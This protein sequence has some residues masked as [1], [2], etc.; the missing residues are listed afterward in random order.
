MNGETRLLV[1]EEAG[2]VDR[3]RLGGGIE[4]NRVLSAV[5]AAGATVRHDSGGRLMVIDASDET[6]EALGREVP[7]VRVVS[8]DEDVLARLPDLDQS[9]VLFA[10]ALAIRNSAAYRERKSRMTPG[11][12]PEEQLLL[13]APCTPEA[14]P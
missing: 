3:G 10:R 8:V 2:A 4:R 7:G 5:A 13:T 14:E 1:L 9:D 6:A 11:E 12:T